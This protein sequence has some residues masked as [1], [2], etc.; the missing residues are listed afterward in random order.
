MFKN[1]KPEEKNNITEEKIPWYRKRWFW[2]AVL[3]AYVPP[4]VYLEIK[5]LQFEQNI[6]FSLPR[7]FTESIYAIL[8]IHAQQILPN[9]YKYNPS[10]FYI[11]YLYIISFLFYIFLAFLIYKIFG[12]KKIK[13]KLALL[14]ITI[15]SLSIFGLAMYFLLFIFM[16]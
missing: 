4:I 11:I 10:I 15:L 6:F 14:L 13:V 1:Q 16:S 12:Q 7:G 3:G 5:I 9:F 8:N 2:G